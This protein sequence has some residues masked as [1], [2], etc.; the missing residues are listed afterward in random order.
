[1]TDPLGES[2]RAAIEGQRR[3]LQQQ[4]DSLQHSQTELRHTLGEVRQRRTG[5]RLWPSR[6]EPRPQT[7]ENL[8]GSF[9]KVRDDDRRRIARDLHDELGQSLIVLS[10]G[11]KAAE[12]MSRDGC[13]L[14]AS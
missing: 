8:P 7:S 6:S 2:L 14:P 1:M 13:C 10:I 9:D 5:N 4:L 11:L 3:A 12:D